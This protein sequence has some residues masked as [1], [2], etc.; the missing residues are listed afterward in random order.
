MFSLGCCEK[1]GVSPRA[2]RK[3]SASSIKRYSRNVACRF[4]LVSVA[5]LPLD[6][7][8]VL[9]RIHYSTTRELGE[10]FSPSR[11]ARLAFYL[12]HGTRKLS[13]RLARK[14]E[15]LYTFVSLIYRMECRRS[16]WRTDFGNSRILWQGFNQLTVSGIIRVPPY[17]IWLSTNL[18]S[19]QT[20]E[21]TWCKA[22]TLASVI[23]L[24]PLVS[25]NLSTIV[26]RVKLLKKKGELNIRHSYIKHI[27]RGNLYKRTYIV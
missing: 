13:K 27:L 17:A 20:E 22:S 23:S 2:Q 6:S 18:G 9:S 24:P 5:F 1:N 16:T 12:R 26:I 15:R 11:K 10:P 21:S 7:L 4:D 25:K 19:L 3:Q 8:F 14:K